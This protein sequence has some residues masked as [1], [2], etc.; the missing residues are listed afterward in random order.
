MLQC[1]LLLHEVEYELYF[2]VGGQGSVYPMDGDAATLHPP[3]PCH[4]AFGE[5][6]DGY[7]EPFH[8]FV[9]R[10]FTDEVLGEEFVF[11]AIV[12]ERLLG[13]AALQ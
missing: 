1:L 13:H 11:E 3:E 5:L 7:F 8:H 2:L 6:V 4:L 10:C 9:I 12:N